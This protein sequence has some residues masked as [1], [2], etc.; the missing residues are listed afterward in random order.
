[1]G[2]RDVLHLVHL[3][4]HGDEELLRGAER[5]L[6]EEGADAILD[7]PRVLNALLTAPEAS[8]ATDLVFYV[9]VRHALLEVGIDDRATADY[10]ASLLVA[11]GRQGRAYRVSEN[12]TE[13]YHYLV[14]MVAR[15]ADADRREAF[16]L[17][18]HLGNF[19]LWLS[20]LFPDYLNARTQRRGAPSISYYERMGA[21]GY[22]LAARSPEAASLGLDRVLS[23]VAET[24][25]GV[26]SA[27]NLVSDRYL[28][29]RG[30]DPVGRLLRDVSSRARER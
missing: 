19:S 24:F 5:R 23:D 20:G 30:G 8:A 11:F 22:R 16:L 12:T 26:R 25:A 17:R 6:D 10:V 29:P 18:S 4:A 28:W 27:L 15:L 9:L 2:R 21:T 3:L 13:E 7:D 14:D 1:V